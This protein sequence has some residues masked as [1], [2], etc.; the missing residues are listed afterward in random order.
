MHGHQATPVLHSK[1]FIHL[2]I[3]GG[4]CVSEGRSDDGL[5][6]L[7]LHLPS[8]MDRCAWHRRPQASREYKYMVTS[9]LLP[10][11]HHHQ[12]TAFSLFFSFCKTNTLYSI[13]TN[14]KA[15]TQRPTW[16]TT[17]ARLKAMPSFSMA[18]LS[19]DRLLR[20]EVKVGKP[21]TALPLTWRFARKRD[22][23]QP[24]R[25]YERVIAMLAKA[26]YGS[27]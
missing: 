20:R 17:P 19:Y 6:T 22:C 21:S 13:K 11:A 10:S 7:C 5:R 2:F 27:G 12:H 24:P 18:A 1:L 9:S 26:A 4:H 23:E 8:S 25:Q 14:G 16:P 15:T 3:R